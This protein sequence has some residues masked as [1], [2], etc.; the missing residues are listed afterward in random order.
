MVVPARAADLITATITLT[1]L[2]AG[3][4]TNLTINGST[5]YWT[6][7]P[8]A[9]LSTHIQ[10]T[11]TIALSATNLINHLGAYP[12]SPA[13]YL[14]MSSPT[15]VVIRGAVGENL[16]VTVSP[17]PGWAIVTYST[18]TVSSP[19][20]AVRVPITVEAASNQIS[21]ASLLAS[22]LVSSTNG[23][24]TNWAA[25]GNY[26]TKGASTQQV[27]IAPVQFNTTLRAANGF[28]ATNGFL[29]SV[30]GISL[31]TTSL[32]NYGNAIRSGGPGGNSLQVGSNAWA[33]GSLSVAIGNNSL[34]SNDNAVAVGTSAIA[35]NT[36]A[37][38]FGNSAG[39]RGDYATAIGSSAAA[40]TNKAVAI[41]ESATASSDSAIALGTASQASGNSAISIGTADIGATAPYAIAIG[42]AAEA[43]GSNSIAIGRGAAVGS[44]FSAAFGP[45]DHL[46]NTV[47][48]TATNQIRLGTAN[49]HVS[50][51]GQLLISGT[52][53]NTTFTGTNIAGGS[54][55]YP[56]FDLTTLAAGNNIAVPFGTNRFIRLTAGSLTAGPSICG[57]IGGATSGGTDGQEVRVHNDTG[58]DVTFAVNTVD[59][60]PANRIETTDGVDAAVE[61][62]AWIDLVYSSADSRWHVASSS[63]GSGSGVEGTNYFAQIQL[64]APQ[65]WN[66]NMTGGIYGYFSNMTAVVTNRMY[67]F[68]STG[69]VQ[70]LEAGWYAFSA[71]ANYEEAAGSATMALDILTNI[72]GATPT[73]AACLDN[74]DVTSTEFSHFATIE[75]IRYL[76]ANTLVTPVLGCLTGSGGGV[77]SNASLTVRGLQGVIGPTG[78]AGTPATDGANFTNVT[79]YGWTN[80]GNVTITTNGITEGNIAYGGFTATNS[81][82]FTNGSRQVLQFT[83]NWI[84]I[85][86]TNL[87]AMAGGDMRDIELE[88]Q[89][90]HFYIATNRVIVINSAFKRFSGAI[91][92]TLGSNKIGILRLRRRAN[93]EASVGVSWEPEL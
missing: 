56:R 35:T 23:I 93:T 58:Y 15:N 4:T 2:P 13:H 37:V 29:H 66:T 26:L 88:F 41:G 57:I 39:A 43:G 60:V 72:A 14:S 5:R 18:Q 12:A 34:A 44:A 42:N 84:W 31:V 91:T 17:S 81:I 85:Q 54:W 79:T 71:Q 73:S 69:T 59:P 30:T 52:Q 82:S 8:V 19:T 87:D 47:V 25:G 90:Q 65:Q 51:P 38:A 36:G 62:N 70:V 33:L 27:V 9:V 46:G 22:A 83:N 45:P 89:P 7:A 49:H 11:N 68:G 1:N 75:R 21:I 16:T 28:A 86:A 63:A 78:P 55:S 64:T 74:A 76:P 3:L 32:V 92:N 24:G 77:L 6:N 48:D 80:R 61:N 10:T 50:I 20:F 67:A 53:S 40:S